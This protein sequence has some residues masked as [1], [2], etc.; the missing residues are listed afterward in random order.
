M[1]T[2]GKNRK[3]NGLHPNPVLDNY[4]TL[5]LKKLFIMKVDNYALTSVNRDRRF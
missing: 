3:T 5:Y 2:E 1:L 4:N